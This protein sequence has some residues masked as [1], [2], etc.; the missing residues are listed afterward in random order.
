MGRKDPS[1][2]RATSEGEREIVVDTPDSSPAEHL[3]GT[4]IIDRLEVC[5]ALGK[6]KE[7]VLL[8][9]EHSERTDVCLALVESSG[10]VSEWCVFGAPRW[11]LLWREATRIDCRGVEHI[12]N[13]D[14]TRLWR[15]R[16]LW[17]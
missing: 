12:S 10:V 1:S 7:A 6:M 14:A 17:G 3:S 9:S 4:D 16:Q 5:M 11:S 15:A 8:M 2:G 13:E